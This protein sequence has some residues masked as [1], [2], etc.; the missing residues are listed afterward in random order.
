MGIRSVSRREALRWFAGAVGVALAQGCAAHRPTEPQETR[1]QPLRINNE[2]ATLRAAIV[3]DA[4]NAVT[5]TPEDFRKKKAERPE[6]FAKHPEA[7]PSSKDR[8][9]EQH[10][11]FRQLLFEHGVTMLQ[12]QTQKGA[13]CQ[14]FARDPCFVVGDTLFIGR[15]RDEYRHGE[16]T[17]LDALRTRVARVVDLSGDGVTIEGGD[18]MVL[19]GGSRVLVGMNEHTNAGGLAK[20]RETLAPSG[21]EVVPVPHKALHLDCC[22]APL[23]NR[24]ALYA[25]GK[26]PKESVRALD[27]F[28]DRLMPLDPDEAALHLAANVFWLNERKVVSGVVAMKTNELL[29]KKDFEVVE[30]DFSDLVS[31]WGSFRCTVCPLERV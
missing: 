14:V 20:L 27:K 17:G 30:L 23:P 15:L 7:G 28:F 4:S 22:L 31:L 18:V 9:I 25:A 8:L 21:V 16:T 10:T 11:R 29:R 3:H 13:Y 19:E 1:M 26:L 24:E 5:F 2:F 6:E 12:P